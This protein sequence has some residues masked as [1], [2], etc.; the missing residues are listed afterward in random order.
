MNQ[1]CK[2]DFVITY[3]TEPTEENI[4]C[5]YFYEVQDLIESAKKK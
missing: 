4:P 1:R 5:A 3:R 2:P